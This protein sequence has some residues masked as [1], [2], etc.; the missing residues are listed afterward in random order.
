MLVAY[1][2]FKCRM[3]LKIH[4]LQSHL[5]LFPDNLGDISDEHDEKFYQD[6]SDIETRYQGK[7]NDKMM[8]DYCW[9]LQRETVASCRRKARSQQHF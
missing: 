9:Y 1:Q 7:P 6:I 8:G 2:K 5:D 4:F 3:P